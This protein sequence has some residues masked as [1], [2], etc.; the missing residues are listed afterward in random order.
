[1]SESLQPYR[2]VRPRCI[3]LWMQPISTDVAHSVVC[4]SVCLSVCLMY[5]IMCCAK[6]AEPIDEPV[7]R[8]PC[9]EPGN[10]V[11][12]SSILELVHYV[13]RLVVWHS[14]RKLIFRRRTFPVLRSTCS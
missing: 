3:F 10:H 9:V 2:F 4:V 14:G 7:L 1:M 12:D 5:L 8:L 6:T 11:L 13:T